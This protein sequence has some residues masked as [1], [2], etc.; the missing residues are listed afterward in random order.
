MWKGSTY[1]QRTRPNIR[2]FALPVLAM[3]M[4]WSNAGFA[5]EIAAV[6]SP[7]PPPVAN[8][9]F[10][11]STGEL[12]LARSANTVEV[13]AVVTTAVAAAVTI[14]SAVSTCSQMVPTNENWQVFKNNYV[15]VPAAGIPNLDKSAAILGGQISKLDQ[16][17]TPTTRR[18]CYISSAS[19]FFTRCIIYRPSA[20]LHAGYPNK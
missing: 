14:Q 2:N 1:T 8:I 20:R 10:V 11:K 16:I 13:A 3:G 15:P 5:Q 6:T 19:K 17:R 9:I 7:K 18:A 12:P 4:L